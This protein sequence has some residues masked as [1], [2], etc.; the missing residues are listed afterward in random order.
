MTDAE[1]AEL[2]AKVMKENP[3]AARLVGITQQAVR[4]IVKDLSQ[5][6]TVAVEIN[7]VKVAGKD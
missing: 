3:L 2:I 7:G 5:D 4:E 1:K 6:G